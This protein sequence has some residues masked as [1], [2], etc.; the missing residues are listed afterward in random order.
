M[1][2]EGGILMRRTSSLWARDRS[3]TNSDT[4]VDAPDLTAC[5]AKQEHRAGLRL[6]EI[7]VARAGVWI[8]SR[9]INQS[10]VVGRFRR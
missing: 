7:W 5:I 3:E 6:L 10:R 8:R 4:T 1:N 2:A 9:R